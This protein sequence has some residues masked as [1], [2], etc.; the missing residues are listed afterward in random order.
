M[1]AAFQD[2]S[3]KEGRNVTVVTQNIDE[4]HQRAGTKDVVELHGSLYKTRCTVCR[5]V[6]VNKNIPICPALEGKG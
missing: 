4:L 2:R 6:V 3:S 5:E 1:I